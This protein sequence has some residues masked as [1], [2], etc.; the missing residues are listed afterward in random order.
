MAQRG[1]VPRR[2]RTFQSGQD[3]LQRQVG[4]RGHAVGSA[5]VD[6]HDVAFGEQPAGEHDA[7]EESLALVRRFGPEDGLPG[8]GEDARRV[9][10]VEQER[11]EGVLGG[12]AGDAVVDGQPVVAAAGVHPERDGAATHLRLL[13]AARPRRGHQAVVAPREHVGRR[14]V[15]DRRAADPLGHGAVERGVAAVDPRR[16]DGHVAVGRGEDDPVPRE[17]PEVARRRERRRDAERRHGRVVD[18]VRAV[19]HRD[20]RVLD[21]EC[22]VGA[23]RRDGG[24]A[25][26][27][28]SNAVRGAREAQVRDGRQPRV[29]VHHEQ[30]RVAGVQPRCVAPPAPELEAPRGGIVHRRADLPRREVARRLGDAQEQEDLAVVP[31][32]GGVEDAH[33]PQVGARRRDHRGRQDRVLGCAARGHRGVVGGSFRTAW[34]R[35]A[36]VHHS[37]PVGA[38]GAAYV[39]PVSRTEEYRWRDRASASGRCST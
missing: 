11:A 25:L 23:R 7:A 21:A 39:L 18:P 27:R 14:R 5:V 32:G 17:R 13:P 34:R 6:A 22:L 16:E 29:A 20:A 15:P 35:V 3:V 8:A 28:E 9:A 37:R 36:S 33:H 24:L 12:G 1:G 2:S 4:D 30:P 38:R 26:H 31:Y 10:P 19:Q